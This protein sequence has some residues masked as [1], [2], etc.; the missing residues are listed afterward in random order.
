MELT[1][2]FANYVKML[3]AYLRWHFLPVEY[4]VKDLSSTS[5]CFYKIPAKLTASQNRMRVKTLVSQD[6]Q[7]LKDLEYLNCRLNER[8]IK[9]ANGKIF[10]FESAFK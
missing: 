10:W 1:E 6:Y 4:A 8:Q 2:I 7:F 5:D 9:T 3:D